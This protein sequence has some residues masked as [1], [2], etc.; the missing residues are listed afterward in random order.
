MSVN[1]TP[2]V[3]VGIPTPIYLLA[4]RTRGVPLLVPTYPTGPF[5]RCILGG[6]GTYPTKKITKKKKKTR[7]FRGGYM[8]DSSL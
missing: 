4:T 2:I 5:Y 7:T 6:G 3:R 1:L 8:W